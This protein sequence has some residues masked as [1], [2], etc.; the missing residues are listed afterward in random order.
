MTN[1]NKRTHDINHSSIPD[2]DFLSFLKLWEFYHHL[3]QTVSR[4]QLRKACQYNFLSYNRMREWTEIHRQLLELV[5]QPSARH[6]AARTTIPRNRKPQSRRTGRTT[7]RSAA[8]ASSDS[9]DASDSRVSAIHRA[10]LS[11]LLSG[12]AYR[13]A[14]REYTGAGGLQ[15]L[16]WPGSGLRRSRPKWIVAA[17]LVETSQRYART[18]A[19]IQPE[20]IEPL[21]PHLVRRSYSDPRWHRKRGAVMAW[22]KVTLM[23]MPIVVRR[24]VRYRPIDPVASRQLFIQDALVQQQLE[25]REPFFEQNRRVREELAEWA[26]RTRRREYLLDDYTIYAFYDQRLPEDVCDWADLRRWIQKAGPA[27]TEALQMSREDLVIDAASPD[28]TQ[29][30]PEQLQAGSLDLPVRYHFEHG[31]ENDGVT[32]VVP[33]Q[34]LSQLSPDKL[35]WLV[36]GLLEEKVI[37]L[38]RSLPKNLRRNFVPVPDTARRV[39]SRLNFGEGSL[40][41]SLAAI[42]GQIAEERITA[43]DFDLTKLPEH[44][45][46]NVQVV[47]EEGKP[48]QTGRNL[49]TLRSEVSEVQSLGN[50]DTQGISEDTWTRSGAVKWDFDDLPSEVSIQRGGVGMMAYP[51][52]VDESTAVGLRLFGSELFAHHQHFRG[53][54]RLYVLATRKSLRARVRWLPQWDETCV[55]AAHIVKPDQLKEQ[56]QDLIAVR[57]FLGNDPLPRTSEAYEARLVDAVERVAVATQEISPLIPRLFQAYQQARLATESLDSNR[58][59]ATRQDIQQQLG[60]LLAN[61]FLSQ[62]PW[63]WL[64]HFPRFLHAIQQ[65][66]EKLVHG[67]EA[68]DGEGLRQ[69]VEYEERYATQRIKNDQMQE[70]DPML[71]QYRWM[72]EEFRVSWFAQSLGTSIKISPQRLDAQWAKIRRA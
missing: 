28:A 26:A 22:E 3:R 30:F 20:W 59:S 40:L 32:I 66:A 42:L 17:E 50:G 68:R 62:T 25:T 19:R 63:E 43:G 35:G 27:A 69:V 2:S 44:L 38:I 47:D 7:D 4:S 70:W 5:P 34:A 18:V 56:I 71:E 60:H 31:A 10:L 15:L 46:I 29:D 8:R 48:V 67:G 11:G 45:K 23:G 41:D 33:A 6:I 14:E 1:S 61:G 53:L 64:Q 54:M 37:A 21:A 49:T 52:L 13:A 51:A 9:P 72:I 16:L 36:P 24:A 55:W 58:W 57:A 12:V 39:V 65:R